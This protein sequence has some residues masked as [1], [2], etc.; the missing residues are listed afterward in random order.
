[1]DEAELKDIEEWCKTE[2]LNRG[3][4]IAHDRFVESLISEVRRLNQ[5]NERKDREIQS[6]HMQGRVFEKGKLEDLKGMSWA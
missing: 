5:E 2:I 1:M 6:L 4:R 3:H